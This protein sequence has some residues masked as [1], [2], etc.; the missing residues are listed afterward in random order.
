MVAWRRT[1]RRRPSGFVVV[2]K[3]LALSCLVRR[4]LYE[5]PVYIRRHG[6]REDRPPNQPSSREDCEKHDRNEKNAPIK[7]AVSP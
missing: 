7:L 3:L 1:F 5:P 2:F 6:G 4:K